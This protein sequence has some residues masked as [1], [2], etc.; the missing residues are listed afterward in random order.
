[1]TA[2]QQLQNYTLRCQGHRILF[3]LSLPLVQLCPLLSLEEPC[4]ELEE[5]QCVNQTTPAS[6]EIRS[7]VLFAVQSQTLL[8][9]ISKL[10]H[11]R[12]FNHS[13]TRL[14]VLTTEMPA[15]SAAMVTDF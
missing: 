2:A 10:N 14:G 13:Q 6:N 9:K 11:H 3:S 12:Y 5:P 7:P 1:M 8:L 15:C 4:R